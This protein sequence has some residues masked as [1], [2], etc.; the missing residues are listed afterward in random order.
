[1]RYQDLVPFFNAMVN[2]NGIFMDSVDAESLGFRQL[3]EI[4]PNWP[5]S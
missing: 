4:D 3:D 1:M 5:T 2:S